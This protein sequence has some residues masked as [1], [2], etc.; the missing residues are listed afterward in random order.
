[1]AIGV[2]LIALLAISVLYI[3]Y[4][5]MWYWWLFGIVEVVGFFYYANYLSKTWSVLS[6]RQFRR[7]L[8]SMA[9]VIRL[10][11]M[12]FLYWF[13]T[14]MNGQ[15]FMFAAAD[16]L[17]YHE[18][19]EWFVMM[20]REGNFLGIWNSQQGVSD[21]G[22]P[23]YLS[24]VYL[25]TDNSIIAVRLL[26]VLWSSLTCIL[27][28]RIAQRNFG[29]PVGRMAAIFCMLM[30]NLIYYCGV[31]L[32]ETEMT[33]LLMAFAERAD[34]VI[35]KERYEVASFA[36]A[37]LLGVSLFTFRT[38]LGAAAMF[39]FI[40]ALVFTNQRVASLGRRWLM[41]I[42][43]AVVALYFVGGRIFGEMQDYW[44]MRDTNQETRLE[45]RARKGN[46]L[47]KY[48]G[49]AVFAPMIFTL[50]FPTM[51]ETPNQETSRLIH[52]GNV[53]KNIMSGLV[54]FA[55]FM[56]I[57]S[58]WWRGNIFQGDWRNHIFIIALLVAYLGI[59]ALS[60]FAHAERFHMPAIP[61]EMIFAAV[62]VSKMTTQRYRRFFTVWCLIMFV[63]FIG[64]N[65]FKMRGR[66]WA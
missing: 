1:M 18:T 58:G 25:L 52:G 12:L 11:A 59:L 54:L 37:I 21:L 40:V 34:Y 17:G 15:P 41:L 7:S 24:F 56:M 23:L 66:G 8:F 42:A 46:V 13:F 44:D 43:V 60:A 28:Y 51:V 63:A 19:A 39:S 2:Y 31:H 62:G 65:W 48:A 55:F 6:E 4:A 3:N 32:K 61:L 45:D 38:V 16:S 29:E 14:I 50:P 36:S 64:W 26:K 49:A 30:P 57:M 35:R 5:M 33:F 22:Y 53:V 47:A 9:F 10:F 27:V 20:L